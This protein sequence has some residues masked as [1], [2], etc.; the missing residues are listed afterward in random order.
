[1]QGAQKR[2]KRHVCATK[3][4]KSENACVT[5]AHIVECTGLPCLH[6]GRAWLGVVLDPHR[7]E[8]FFHQRRPASTSSPSSRC[9]PLGTKWVGLKRLDRLPGPECRSRIQPLMCA[10]HPASGVSRDSTD[11]IRCQSSCWVGQ[12]DAQSTKSMTH[13]M[14]MYEYHEWCRTSSKATDSSLWLYGVKLADSEAA[15]AIRIIGNQ[16]HSGVV[17]LRFSTPVDSNRRQPQRDLQNLASSSKLQATFKSPNKPLW[18][19][20]ETS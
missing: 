13:S 18:T 9:H 3:K 8:N 6:E 2:A 1:M 5:R 17:N 11:Q 15:R 12:L 4:Q 16:F 19:S 20:R 10:P 7:P 14:N